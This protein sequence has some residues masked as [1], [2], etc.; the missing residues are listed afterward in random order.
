MAHGWKGAS[1]RPFLTTRPGKVWGALGAQ[2]VF[3]R[4]GGSWAVGVLG[5]SMG[6][7]GVWVGCEGLGD[8]RDP[9]ASG[10]SGR[11]QKAWGAQR[12]LG[13]QGLFPRFGSQLDIPCSLSHMALHTQ[14][15]TL[16]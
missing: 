2:W 8:H 10:G 13:V 6:S 16:M 5:K 7:S 12:G 14:M 3:E 4:S 1:A 15:K 11:P 9:E